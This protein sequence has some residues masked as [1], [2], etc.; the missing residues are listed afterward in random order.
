M[1]IVLP[2][3]AWGAGVALA[4]SP[5]LDWIC[6]TG[7]LECLAPPVFFGLGLGLALGW[8]LLHLAGV[9]PAWAV[10]LLGLILSVALIAI[11]LRAWPALFLP[12]LA[13][14]LCPLGYAS[15]A[16]A[17]AR[18]KAKV[19][20]ASTTWSPP[21]TCDQCPHPISAHQ[22]WAPDAVCDG[23]MH[24]TADGCVSCW[25]SW[26]RRSAGPPAR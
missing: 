8:P 26:P 6:P 2:L 25:H 18:L 16:Y 12:P 21:A 14:V 17:V 4:A 24:C 1:G 13:V 10:A 9:R 15:A 20:S 19:V 3:V 11:I 23:W 5:V 7:G 22:V